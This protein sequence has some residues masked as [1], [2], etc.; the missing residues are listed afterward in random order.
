[1]RLYVNVFMIFAADSHFYLW[2]RGMDPKE[3]ED[4][5]EEE[6][7]NRIKAGRHVVAIRPERS[8]GVHVAVEIHDVDPPYNPGAWDHIAEASL[9]LPTGRLQ[10][11]ET[12]GRP[13][14]DFVL[15]P[16]WY[17]VRTHHGGFNTIAPSG[18]AGDDLYVVILWP[19]PPAP[20]RV[21]KQCGPVSPS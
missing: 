19:A 5:T 17:R 3:S 12:V 13:V 16:G 11:H 21:V 8:T 4:D 14:G 18:L 7:R 6:A 2:D 20:V 10:V 9:H 1:M 15:E